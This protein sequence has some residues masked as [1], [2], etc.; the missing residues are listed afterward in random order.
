MQKRFKHVLFELNINFLLIFRLCQQSGV[1][2]SIKMAGGVIKAGL[3]NGEMGMAN[4]RSLSHGLTRKRRGQGTEP[5]RKTPGWP[6]CALGLGLASARG[7][8]SAAAGSTTGA[9]T[10]REPTRGRAP[11]WQHTWG[12]RM[13]TIF[14]PCNDSGFHDV[15]EA[16]EC[17][18]VSYDWS[19]A[20]RLW[21]NN[22]PAPMGDERLLLTQAE[23][24]W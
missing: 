14:M 6:V 15:A 11:R 10:S 19:N 1:V 3:V 24:A 5:T 7:C 13:S 2:R 9:M 12:M 20:K 8:G 22:R 18:I 21:V 23:M 17:G 4:R 16:I